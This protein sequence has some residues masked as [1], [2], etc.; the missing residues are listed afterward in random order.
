MCLHLHMCN[1]C[2]LEGSNSTAN[3]TVS[4]LE[5]QKGTGWISW[6]NMNRLFFDRPV[7]GGHRRLSQSQTDNLF[8][9]LQCKR[10]SN[11]I[12]IFLNPSDY[13]ATSYWSPYHYDVNLTSCVHFS[14]LSYRS[15][16]CTEMNTLVMLTDFKHAPNY[17]VSTITFLEN[18]LC[19]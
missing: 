12:F 10:H 9:T 16:N 18:E 14:S 4:F 13:H 19:F 7:S 17:S 1:Y 5:G 8:I 2:N 3:R 11:S 6:L 15:S